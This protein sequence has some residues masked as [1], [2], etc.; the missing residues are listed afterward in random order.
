MLQRIALFIAA[1]AAAFVIAIGISAANRAPSTQ[2]TI[3][4]ATTV[5]VDQSTNPPVQVDT[6]YVPAP[7]PPT[8]VTVHRNVPPSGEHETEGAG[9]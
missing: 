8:T 3:D 6:V 4:P 7:V 9:D 5:A 2:G 1:L